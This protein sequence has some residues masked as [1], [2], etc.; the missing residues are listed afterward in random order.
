MKMANTP[1]S[2]PNELL[3]VIVRNLEKVDLKNVRLACKTLASM[4]EPILFRELVLVPLSRLPG[5]VR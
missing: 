3:Q 4:A 5:R 1:P 2:L